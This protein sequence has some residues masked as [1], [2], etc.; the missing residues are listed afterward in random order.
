MQSC[1]IK[2]NTPGGN[3]RRVITDHE[4]IDDLRRQID[5]FLKETEEAIK[6]GK[7]L[8]ITCSSC[9]NGMKFKNCFKS[10][11]KTGDNKLTPI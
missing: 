2:I 8:S 1:K 9:C 10:K 4:D 6:A 7:N 11:I 3:I 5:I